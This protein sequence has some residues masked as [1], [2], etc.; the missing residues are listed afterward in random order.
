MARY[1]IQLLRAGR[2]ALDAGSMFGLVPRVVWE[3]TVAVDAKHRVELTHNCL[4]AESVDG[5][6]RRKI[7]IETGTGNK[8]DAKMAS[9]FNLENRWVADALAEIGVE[10]GQITDVLVTHLHFDH[11]GGLTRRC[12]PGETP[13]WTVPGSDGTPGAVKR[14]FPGARVHVQ[15]R[16]WLDALANR[17]VMTKTYYRDHIVPIESQ[18]LLHDSHRPF[19][20]GSIPDRDAVPVLPTD[21]RCTQVLPGVRV[22]LV[23]GHTWGQQAV[24]IDD[25]QGRTLV[26][27]PDVLPT[28]WHLGA[29]YSLAYDVEPYT[30]MLSKRWFL[31]S[32]ADLG[33]HLLLDHEPGHACVR[34]EHDGKGWFT[35]HDA[36]LPAA[37]PAGVR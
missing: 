8:L 31:A 25:A 22:L 18:L 3:K 28:R 36:P 4:Y 7:L 17:S 13:D 2:L 15:R 21:V 34:C 33:W 37:I 26:F 20:T 29:A 16:E 23:P 27:T 30:S 14:T 6:E 24:L 10:C 19:A 1:R 32:A 11:A 9:V 12:E 35:L 5:P